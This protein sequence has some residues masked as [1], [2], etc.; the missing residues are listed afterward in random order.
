MNDIRMCI[1]L[2]IFVTVREHL[3]CREHLLNTM[4]DDKYL[5]NFGHQNT[6]D[7]LDDIFGQHWT[8]H[9]TGFEKCPNLAPLED[10]VNQ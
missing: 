6:L 10:T 8:S 5:D 2:C 7:I 3:T 1:F 9:W 4:S